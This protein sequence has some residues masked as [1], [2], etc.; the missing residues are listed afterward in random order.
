MPTYGLDSKIRL[1]GAFW[2]PGQKE[3]L[4]TGEVRTKTGRLFFEEA[5]TYSTLTRHALSAIVTSMNRSES[6]V[7]DVLLGDTDERKCTLLNL[8]EIGSRGMNDLAQNISVGGTDWRVSTVVMGLHIESWN[9]KDLDGFA[10]YLSDLDRWTPLPWQLNWSTEVRSINLPTEPLTLFQFSSLTPKA[11]VSLQV[12]AD[13]VH[14]GSRIKLEPLIRIR[15]L[16]KDKC[17]LAWVLQQ[18]SRISGFFTLVLGTSVT[19]RGVQIFQ[20]KD[21]AYVVRGK[22]SI[23][24][25]KPDVQS[26]IRCDLSQLAFAFSKWIAVPNSEQPVE[27]T[28][29]GMLRATKLFTETEFLSLAQSLEAFGRI[30]FN[31]PV[32]P[33]EEFKRG[34]KELHTALS[35]VWQSGEFV[36]RC[37]VN[38]KHA[39]EP[40]FAERIESILNMFTPGFCLRLVGDRELFSEQLR[41]TRNYYTHLGTKEGRSVLRGG[42]GLFLFNRKL[43]A[44][45]RCVMLLDLG[46]PE[47]IVRE[48]ILYE[49]N[50]W[51]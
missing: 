31:N 15:V 16:P 33:E 1:T 25:K 18:S 8:Q 49:R 13:H 39:N 37:V 42:K 12:F 2:I 26:W 27:K 22:S 11:E 32:I 5:A 4:R 45:L 30:R 3:T 47:E 51:T 24:P 19:V 50:K 40:N 21:D 46:F 6:N 17:S 44:V 38:L 14:E 29:L 41:Q 36:K 9:S 10:M 35:N 28:V 48:P 20:G 7:I 43:H 23:K 34:L